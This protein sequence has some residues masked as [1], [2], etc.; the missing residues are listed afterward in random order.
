[1]APVEGDTTL[2]GPDSLSFAV[3]SMGQ[4]GTMVPASFASGG[5]GEAK[6]Q[7]SGA[8]SNPAEDEADKSLS[9][10][11]HDLEFRD[12]AFV[13]DSE[14]RGSRDGLVFK[15]GAQG[16]GYYTNKPL[17]ELWKAR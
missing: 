2:M 8:A 1:M 7:P 10:L 9:K 16:V 17:A 4:R 6:A 11:L 3:P 5:E 14:Y 15:D 13:V 12:P